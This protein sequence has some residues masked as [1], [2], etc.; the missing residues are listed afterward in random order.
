MQFFGCHLQFA[1]GNTRIFLCRFLHCADGR[2]GDGVSHTMTIYVGFAL[3]HAVLRLAG[4]DPAEY[5]RK[6]LTEFGYSFTTT[7]E[8]DIGRGVKEKLCYIATQSS[9]RLRRFRQEADPYA[10]RRKHHHCRRR[11]FPFRESFLFSQF[12]WH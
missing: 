9:N 11:T 1:G 12:H 2:R 7:A 6:I 5:L 10:L 8:R 4:R 3:H